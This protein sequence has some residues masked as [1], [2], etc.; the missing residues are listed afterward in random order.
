MSI[1]ARW[2]LDYTAG[3]DVHWSC[4]NYQFAN[5]PKGLQR[6]RDHHWKALEK[7]HPMGVVLL[8]KMLDFKDSGTVAGGNIP[9][10]S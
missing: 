4:I 8:I 5:Q 6:I 1:H 9:K 3:L 7:V 2:N 10:N